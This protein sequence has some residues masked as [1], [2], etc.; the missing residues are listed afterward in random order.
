MAELLLEI[1]TEEIPAGYLESGLEAFRTLLQDFLRQQG[2]PV[3]VPLAA[4][5]TPR[6]LVLIGEKVG[7]KQADRVE[8]ITGPPKAVAF[9]ASGNPTKAAKGFAAKQGVSVE[10]LRVIQTPKG[11]YVHVSKEVKGK[12]TRDLLAEALGDIIAAIPWPKSMRWGKLDFSFVRPIHWVLALFDGQTIPVEIAAIRSGASTRGHRF[13]APE[14]ITVSSVREYR[15]CLQAR[16]VMID[17][18]ERRQEVLRGVNEAAASV[19]GRIRPDPD[20]AQTVANLVE[21]PS[22][23]CGGFD[24]SFLRLPEPVLITPM[25]EHQKYF[26][27]YGPDGRLLPHF[28]AVNNTLARDPTLVK[29]GHERVLRAR[30]SDAAF[31]FEEDRKRPLLDRL[32][33]LKKVI[34]QTDLGTSWAKVERFRKVAAWIGQVAMPEDLADID[35]ACRL[36]KCDLVTQMVT[37]FPSLQGLMGREYARLEGYP[38]RVCRAVYEHYLP[39]RA[40]ERLPSEPLGAVVGVA[41]RIDTVSGC[42]AV[43][44]E[45]TGT[46]DPYALRRHVLAILRILEHTGW[47][48]AVPDLIRKSIEVLSESI[49]LEQEEVFAR[50]MA[51]FRERARQWMLRRGYRGDVIEAVLS[52]GLG[53]IRDLGARIGALQTFVGEAE[54][55]ESMANTFKRVFNMVKKQ[56]AR[57]QVDPRSFA[58]PCEADLWEAVG[59]VAA[60][61]ARCLESKDHPGAIKALLALR[62]PVAAFFDGVEIMT[63]ESQTLQDNRIGLL[64]EVAELFTKVADF[65]RIAP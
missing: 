23:V 9:D 28:V 7:Q 16:Y 53:D 30:L 20:L 34:Y 29:R 56:S 65:S 15:E 43:G 26:P 12:A 5:G 57:F 61:L 19:G 59:R 38:E 6:R 32:E 51:F 37:E 21:Y 1:G 39:S 22:A 25:K 60:D 2:V 18:E 40:G 55:F 24:E 42:F 64:Q 10:A 48:I 49:P 33:D 4:Y 63:K 47:P 54:T 14:A 50:V 36:C 17:P 27:V 58:V 11:E 52:T 13:M 3:E 41:D 8:E 45:P 44:L 35:L 62:Q 46:A 31:F